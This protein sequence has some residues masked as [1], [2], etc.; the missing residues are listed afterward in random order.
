MVIAVRICNEFTNNGKFIFTLQALIDMGK[1]VKAEGKIPNSWLCH[2][3][4]VVIDANRRGYPFFHNF[5]KRAKCTPC[6]GAGPYSYR[7]DEKQ[8]VWF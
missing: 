7:L 1:F 4:A 5:Q 2:F 8:S 3:N 6:F